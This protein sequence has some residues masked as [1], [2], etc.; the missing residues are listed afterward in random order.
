MTS[1]LDRRVPSAN[2]ELA[3][4]GGKELRAGALQRLLYSPKANAEMDARLRETLLESKLQ[5]GEPRRLVHS[6]RKSA[7]RL[8]LW[9][10]VVDSCS[11]RPAFASLVRQ[12]DPPP[13][14]WYTPEQ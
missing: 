12:I 10:L 8:E 13:F 5:R 7:A 9:P 11:G 3:P 6:L 4:H 14:R 2:Q 1:S